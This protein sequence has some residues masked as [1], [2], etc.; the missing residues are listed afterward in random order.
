MK[1]KR[2]AGELVQLDRSYLEEEDYKGGANILGVFSHPPPSALYKFVEQNADK[3]IQNIHVCRKPIP[4]FIDRVLNLISLGHWDREKSR[5]NYDKMFHLWMSFVVLDSSGHT[6]ERWILE[7]NQTFTLFQDND[8][9]G[10][11][12]INIPI[13]QPIKVL[14]FWKRPIEKYGEGKLLTYD[15]L[16]AN[17]QDFISDMLEA[18]G[19]LSEGLRKF[20]KQPAETLL[21]HYAHKIV[22]STTDIAAKVF[23]LLRGR[24]KGRRGG[25]CMECGGRFTD[26]DSEKLVQNLN[27]DIS[28]FKFKIPDITEGLNVEAE[29][30]QDPATNVTDCD[31]ILTGKIALAHLLEHPNYY[32]I[33]KTVHL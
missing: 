16:Y 7:K 5:L 4:Y 3:Y 25:G 28:D 14:D 2:R 31:L 33:L 13:S 32:R 20:I 19:L 23:K 10:E 11:C 27:M 26:L 24:G 8:V 22:R 1:K 12:E 17:C 9:K 29:H 18:N 21:P 30:C 15:P 6:S